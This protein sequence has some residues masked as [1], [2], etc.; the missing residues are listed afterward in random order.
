VE[1]LKEL[2]TRST[3]IKLID[4]KVENDMFNRY[5][6]DDNNPKID[7]YKVLMKYFRNLLNS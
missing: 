5:H 1:D 7:I 3:K 6:A 4:W 2:K